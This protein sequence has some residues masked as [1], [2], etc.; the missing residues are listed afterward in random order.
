M[1]LARWFLTLSVFESFLKTGTVLQCERN[2]PADAKIKMLVPAYEQGGVWLVVE[3]AEF[4][5]VTNGRLLPQFMITIRD[6]Q[7]A[8][9]IVPP[10]PLCTTTFAGK[11]VLPPTGEAA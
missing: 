5:E 6:V 9:D 11:P 1:P 4:P 2:F 8:E 7:Y 10:L 3:S